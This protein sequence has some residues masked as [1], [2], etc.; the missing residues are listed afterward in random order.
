[1]R[2]IG[3]IFL[4]FLLCSLFV[5]HAEKRTVTRKSDVSYFLK[6][7][8]FRLSPFEITIFENN[9]CYG[10]MRIIVT[11][12]STLK[13]WLEVR[14]KIPLV[15]HHMF[16]D[17]YQSLNYLWDRT[18]IPDHKILKKRLQTVADKVLG[19]GKIEEVTI[20]LIYFYEENK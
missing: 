20:G 1:L 5:L 14:S 11:L 19:H 17:L 16:V 7:P 6:K 4:C 9:A 3:K 2:I 13:D 12:K 8:Y 18:N 10:T 15:Y